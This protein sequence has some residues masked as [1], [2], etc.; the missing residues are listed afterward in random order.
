[1]RASHSEC[2]YI[3]F[4]A[5]NY[6]TENNARMDSLPRIRYMCV[7][8]CLSQ[9]IYRLWHETLKRFVW[10]WQ[11]MFRFAGNTINVVNHRNNHHRIIINVSRNESFEFERQKTKNHFAPFL[12]HSLLLYLFICLC[13]SVCVW[14]FFSHI[15]FKTTPSDRCDAFIVTNE[16]K[17]DDFE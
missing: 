1:M 15:H 5:W 2:V 8:V 14:V 6:Q 13:I 12:S 9:C 11:N 16:K 7:C 3:F 10:H 4:F 17:R